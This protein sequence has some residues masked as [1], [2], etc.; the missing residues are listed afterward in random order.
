METLPRGQRRLT[1]N[2]TF[3]VSESPVGCSRMMTTYCVTCRP[4]SRPPS[5]GT[6][7]GRTRGVRAPSISPPSPPRG[8]IRREP[9]GGTGVSM[10]GS[11]WRKLAD[12]TVAGCTRRLI[13]HQFRPH[14]NSRN[15]SGSSPVAIYPC[16][17]WRGANKMSPALISTVLAPISTKPLPER[18]TKHCSRSA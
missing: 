17:T 8:R 16:P 1:G 9:P 13:T 5:C 7:E 10:D 3:P 18:I 4:K 15:L 2:N 6:P 11:P 12:Q 14:S